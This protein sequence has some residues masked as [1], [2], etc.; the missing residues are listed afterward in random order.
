MAAQQNDD[1]L[2][3]ALRDFQII[4]LLESVQRQQ[5]QIAAQIFA[6]S[7]SAVPALQAFCDKKFAALHQSA[8]K[9]P[10]P[11]RGW[12]M[13]ATNDQVRAILRQK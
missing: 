9:K 1:A 5:P 3:T 4:E 13:K 6:E 12:D 2:R 8:T 10:A 11:K 7:P